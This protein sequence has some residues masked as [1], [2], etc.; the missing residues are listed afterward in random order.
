MTPSENLRLLSTG[1]RFALLVADVLEVMPQYGYSGRVAD[2]AIC[3]AA[4]ETGLFTSDL[5]LRADNAFGMRIANVRPQPWVIGESNSYAVYDT[6][7][8]SV[9][10]YFDRQRAFNIPNTDNFD[11]YAA[12]TQASGYAT[13]QHYIE[14]WKGLLND[15]AASDYATAFRL[16]DVP[17]EVDPGG[18]GP[19]AQ[20]G[21]SPLLLLALAYGAY[22]MVS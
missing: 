22:K 20:A 8:G 3:Q 19:V 21:T 1:E 16:N 11:E 2:F 14:A 4:H 15:V 6:L 12:A 5:L 10:D 18:G 17:P 9:H 7:K 13:A